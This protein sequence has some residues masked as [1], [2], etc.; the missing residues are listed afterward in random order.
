MKTTTMS[1]SPRRKGAGSPKK[2]ND[3][4]RFDRDKDNAVDK[5]LESPTSVTMQNSFLIQNADQSFDQYYYQHL[6]KRKQQTMRGDMAKEP[7]FGL[8]QYKRPPA[9]DG[10]FAELYEG[11]LIMMGGDRHHMPYNDMYVLKMK[12]EI[13]SITDQLKM[14]T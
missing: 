10:H 11:N 12:H 6:K 2:L 3:I 8:V 7:T 13:L 1:S 14:E 4:F 9:R 5:A